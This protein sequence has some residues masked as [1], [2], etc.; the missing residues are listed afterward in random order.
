VQVYAYDADGRYVTNDDTDT[1]GNYI[2]TG[3]PTGSY[4]LYF[5]IAIPIYQGCSV[6][7]LIISEYYNDKPNLAT[8]D[9]IPVT[10]PNIV[11]SIDVVMSVPDGLFDKHVYLPIVQ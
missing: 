7:Y 10:A 1:H 6:S 11:S 4:R 8:A 3:L 2:I 9:A 5:H